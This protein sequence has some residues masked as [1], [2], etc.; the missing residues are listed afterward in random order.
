MRLIALLVV[1]AAC[2]CDSQPGQTEEAVAR[3]NIHTNLVEVRGV[4]V[5]VTEIR[6]GEICLSRQVIS[7]NNGIEIYGENARCDASWEYIRT[8]LD[9]AEC[10]HSR[11]DG[12]GLANWQYD[13][14]SSGQWDGLRFNEDHRYVVVDF[15]DEAVELFLCLRDEILPGSVIIW[16]S[17]QYI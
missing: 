10:A 4:T 1:F 14:A 13:N 8:C 7:R 16:N 5:A 15:F 12:S 2:V 3:M 11:V 9:R 6:L 17:P